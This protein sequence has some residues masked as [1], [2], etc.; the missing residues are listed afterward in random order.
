MKIDKVHHATWLGLG[1]VETT[2]ILLESG[3][4][5]F[6]GMQ[7]A[8][9][10]KMWH[11]IDPTDKYE[12]AW[13]RLAGIGWTPGS[14]APVVTNPAPDQISVTFDACA[15]FGQKYVDYV[16]SDNSALKSSCLVPQQKFPLPAGKTLTIYR[17]EAAAG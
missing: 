4:H 3:A 10:T 6:N 13:N 14:G 12:F 15:P 5:A 11:E 16:L 7:G 8:P 2:A 9:S 1:D 17:V